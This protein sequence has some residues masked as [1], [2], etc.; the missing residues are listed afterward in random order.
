MNECEN[1]LSFNITF[2]IIFHCFKSCKRKMFL[3]ACLFFFILGS[4]LLFS[5]IWISLQK[6]PYFPNKN[7]EKIFIGFFR[8]W[9]RK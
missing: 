1:E 4:N 6:N 7:N 2:P 9:E 5:G 8:K 3:K